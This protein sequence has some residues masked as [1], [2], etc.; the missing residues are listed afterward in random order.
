MIYILQPMKS[1]T[2]SEND[3]K[4]IFVIVKSHLFRIFHDDGEWMRTCLKMSIYLFLF[5][6]HQRLVVYAM[7][8]VQKTCDISDCET[9]M[10]VTWPVTLYAAY[11]IIYISYYYFQ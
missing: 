7:L 6:L 5:C 10:L 9:I 2:S 8:I 4:P 1:E 3:Q 11:I